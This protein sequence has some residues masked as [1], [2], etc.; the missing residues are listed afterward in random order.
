MKQPPPG[1]T[2]EGHEPTK[3]QGDHT[4][5]NI[6]HSAP[7]GEALTVTVDTWTNPATA[8]IERIIREQCDADL[9][10][11]RARFPHSTS[12]L[13]LNPVDGRI[14]QGMQR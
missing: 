5:S 3:I 12:F 9:R 6:F 8:S 7:S 4:M 14:P 10:G 11:R 13:A 1:Q 2:G